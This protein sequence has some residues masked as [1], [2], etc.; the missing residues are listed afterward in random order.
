MAIV[1]S[2]RD[3]SPKADRRESQTLRVSVATQFPSRKSLKSWRLQRMGT[4][5]LVYR[6]NPRIVK[7]FVAIFVPYSPINGLI[8]ASV[9]LLLAAFPFIFE[10]LSLASEAR[11]L[12]AR[13]MPCTPHHVSLS[14]EHFAL[15]D[16]ITAKP[17]KQNSS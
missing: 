1:Q 3:S 5:P 4:T 11:S 15:A 2:K 8:T 14:I 13:R 16:L 9:P 17:N 6:P 7:D 10:A 12:R